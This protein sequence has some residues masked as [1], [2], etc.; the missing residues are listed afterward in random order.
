M[1]HKYM[2]SFLTCIDWEGYNCIDY[3]LELNVKAKALWIGH[4]IHILPDPFQIHTCIGDKDKMHIAV[5]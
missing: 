4:N 3:N 5:Q 2:S 1:F